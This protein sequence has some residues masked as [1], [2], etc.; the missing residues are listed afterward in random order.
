MLHFLA[1]SYSQFFQ[2]FANIFIPS[3]LL[4]TYQLLLLTY[5]L[6]LLTYQLLLG[7]L[8]SALE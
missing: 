5:Q 8:C 7:G 3:V 2:L 4:L 6:L 1:G